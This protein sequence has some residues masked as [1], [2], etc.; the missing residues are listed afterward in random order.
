MPIDI[1]KIDRCFIQDIEKDDFAKSFVKIVTELANVI[2]VRTCIEGV[3]GQEQVDI[4]RELNVH[5]IQGY[6]FGKPM[7]VTDFEEHYL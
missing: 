2:H 6:F 3:E 4:L 1:I 7:P 5:M